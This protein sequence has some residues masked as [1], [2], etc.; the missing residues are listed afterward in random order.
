MISWRMFGCGGKGRGRGW[1]SIISWEIFRWGVGGEPASCR[2]KSSGGGGVG[3]RVV[4]G[5][6]S[7]GGE[8]GPASFR[9]KSSGAEGGGTAE[10]AE[11]AL[12]ALKQMEFHVFCFDFF[13]IFLGNWV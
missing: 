11:S 13:L 9:G 1:A 2:G 10:N 8:G 7:G 6:S 3:T 4:R 5:K 12:S